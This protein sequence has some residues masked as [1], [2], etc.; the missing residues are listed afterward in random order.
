[1]F[2]AQAGTV[3]V[4]FFVIFA[5]VGLLLLNSMLMAVFERIRELG[6]LKALGVGPGQILA[7][8][9]AE[10]AIQALIAIV[11]G[12]ILSIPGLYVLATHGVDLT[13]GSGGSVGGV[14]MSPMWKGVVT[15]ATVSRPVIALVVVVGIA[16]LYPALKAALIR[17]VEAMHHREEPP[18]T[19][20][21]AP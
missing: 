14:A 19:E 13:L 12:T 20:H 1:M 15:A 16:V 9:L 10:S 6:L 2:D 21:V 7:L 17:P 11:V 8:I 4:A 5:A 18:A 3:W